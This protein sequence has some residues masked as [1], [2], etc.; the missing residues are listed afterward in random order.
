MRRV[1]GRHFLMWRVGAA[2]SGQDL[3]GLREQLVCAPQSG[4]VVARLSRGGVMS[5]RGQASRR[6]WRRGV[7]GELM[8]LLRQTC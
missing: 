1:L 6:G 5:C 7:G 3:C 4:G 8:H 2:D